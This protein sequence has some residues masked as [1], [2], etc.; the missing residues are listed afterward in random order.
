VTSFAKADTEGQ[1]TVSLKDLRQQTRL[2]E[3]QVSGAIETL[4]TT[5]R[6]AVKWITKIVH[7]GDLEVQLYPGTGWPNRVIILFTSVRT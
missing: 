4:M 3:M 1:L 6:I 5:R 2:N 7:E